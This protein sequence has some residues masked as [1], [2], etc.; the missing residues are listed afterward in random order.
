MQASFLVF[1]FCTDTADVKRFHNHDVLINI[2]I[3]IP[4]C[5][6][7]ETFSTTFE[8]FGKRKVESRKLRGV[9]ATEGGRRVAPSLLS[10]RARPDWLL[11]RLSVF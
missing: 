6:L 8:K 4:K 11:A 5:N 3:I 10:I 2:F 1:L 7:I 9:R